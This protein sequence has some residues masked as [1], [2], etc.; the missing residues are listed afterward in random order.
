MMA[1]AAAAAVQPAAVLVAL[2]A[3]PSSLALAARVVR[4]RRPGPT[5]PPAT[6]AFLAAIFPVAAAVAGAGAA[7]THSTAPRFRVGH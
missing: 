1:P 5:A 2:A 4:R 6:L 3:Q 7:F